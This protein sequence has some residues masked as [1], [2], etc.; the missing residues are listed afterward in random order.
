MLRIIIF[1][2]IIIIISSLCFTIQRPLIKWTKKGINDTFS[3]NFA[4]KSSLETPLTNTQLIAILTD[5]IDTISNHE[6]ILNVINPEYSIHPISFNQDDSEVINSNNVIFD[7]SDWNVKMRK[8]LGIVDSQHDSLVVLYPM[9][10]NTNY[11]FSNDLKDLEK[12]TNLDLMR[13]SLI[14]IS[15]QPPNPLDCSAG[16]IDIHI[17]EL[18]KLLIGVGGK[19]SIVDTTTYDASMVNTMITQLQ[20]DK[21]K[22][23]AKSQ[24][25]NNTG[26]QP[27]LSISDANAIYKGN[28][29]TQLYSIVKT[30]DDSIKKLQD[31]IEKRINHY[32][33][34]DNPDTNI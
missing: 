10:L 27:T 28:Y 31:N 33:N 21:A 14:E 16:A 23:I 11:V 24:L 1:L 22:V 4:D 25:P 3:E 18:K 29:L 20:T 32:Y 7:P 5:L 26:C 15:T 2:L 13:A 6:T 30:Q 34:L 19:P 17:G 9:H 12:G 8:I